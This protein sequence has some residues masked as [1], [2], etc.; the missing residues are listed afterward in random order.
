MWGCLHGFDQCLARHAALQ[1]AEFVSGDDDDFI[2]PMHRYVLRSLAAD[3]AHE[4]TE[5]AFT[6]CSCHWPTRSLAGRDLAPLGR[7]RWDLD[8]LVMLTGYAESAGF[9]R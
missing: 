4:L 8:N 5:P 1:P 6:S 3:P 2:A 9:L 7:E